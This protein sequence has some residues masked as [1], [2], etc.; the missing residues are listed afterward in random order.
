MYGNVF[1]HGTGTESIDDVVCRNKAILANRSR[2]SPVRWA[3][4]SSRLVAAVR[5]S[6][7]S[8]RPSAHCLKS[9][10]ALG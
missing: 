7:F 5:T 9:N 6:Q 10:T 1:P 3:L 4:G 8:P 2:V